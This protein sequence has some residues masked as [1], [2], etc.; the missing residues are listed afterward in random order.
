[1]NDS[2]VQERYVYLEG[3]IELPE[4]ILPYTTEIKLALKNSSVENMETI[5]IRLGEGPGTMNDLPDDYTESDLII[6]DF[7]GEEIPYGS[8]VRI[9]GIWERNTYASS[10]S[11]RFYAEEIVVIR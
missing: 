11:G 8:R 5:D 4:Y 9:Y 1:M 6:R 2:T 10:V 7:K 3:I